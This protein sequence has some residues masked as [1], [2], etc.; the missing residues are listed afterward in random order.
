MILV[1]SHIIKKG[2]RTNVK[3]LFFNMY[4]TCNKF[5]KHSHHKM[6][7]VVSH[8]I[9]KGIRTNV[10]LFFCI[11]TTC[12][13]YIN[14]KYHIW[15]HLLRWIVFFHIYRII[16]YASG[17]LFIEK[18]AFE[19]TDYFERLRSFDTRRVHLLYPTVTLHPFLAD[20]LHWR[21][22][23]THRPTTLWRAC[24]HTAHAQCTGKTPVCNGTSFGV[25]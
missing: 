4:T 12:N 5:I 19:R 3:L 11:Y 22:R 7:L 13:S 18:H 2:T 8:I 1:A 10:K 17:T 9:K 16:K 24:G 6:I 15:L 23:Q 25:H 14:K 20:F 21:K